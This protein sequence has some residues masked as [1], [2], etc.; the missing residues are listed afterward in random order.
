MRGERGGGRGLWMFFGWITVTTP[1]NGVLVYH[2]SHSAVPFHPRPHGRRNL[3]LN[4][5]EGHRTG[6]RVVSSPISTTTHAVSTSSLTTAGCPR[7]GRG[8]Q[9]IRSQTAP[10]CYLFGIHLCI[11]RPRSRRRQPGALERQ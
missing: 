6:A 4:D 3:I 2:L 1:P 9:P 11:P 7:D 10:Y 5:V 8:Q